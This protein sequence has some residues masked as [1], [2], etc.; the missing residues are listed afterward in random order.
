[1]ELISLGI[2][3]LE[4]H[5]QLV[6]VR[7]AHAMSWKQAWMW[8][9]ASDTGRADVDEKEGLVRNVVC[10]VDVPVREEKRST[11][12]GVAR[13]LHTANWITESC[14]HAGCKRASHTHTHTRMELS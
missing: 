1:M 7:E 4:I 8:Y 12:T 10:C 11:L 2:A 6:G 9:S 14:L 5:S 13:E 3:S